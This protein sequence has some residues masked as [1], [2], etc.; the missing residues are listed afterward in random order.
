MSFNYPY[1]RHNPQDSWSIGS[2]EYGKSAAMGSPGSANSGTMMPEND[3]SPGFRNPWYSPSQLGQ[4]SLAGSMNNSPQHSPQL[5]LLQQKKQPFNNQLQT[6]YEN[7]D[8]QL[9]SQQPTIYPPSRADNPFNHYYTNQEVSLHHMPDRRMSAAVDGPLYNPYN[10]AMHLHSS[11][12]TNSQ[13][14]PPGSAQNALPF[15]SSMAYNSARRSS[16]AAGANSYQRTP[17]QSR[18]FSGVNVPP[19]APFIGVPPAGPPTK[20]T[21]RLTKIRSKN[22]LKPKIHHQ[23]KYRRRSINSMHISPV[24]ALSVYLTESYSMCQPQKFRYSKTSNPKRVLT[25]PSEPKFNNGYDNVDSDYILYVNDMLGVEEGRKYVVLDLLGSG[26]FGQ[27]VKC[28]NLANQSV[29]A[30]K[31][32]K[33]SAPFLNQSLSEV[34]LLE[35]LNQNSSSSNFIKLLDT[36]MHKEHLCLVFEI[37]ASN[38]YELIKQNQF[39]GLNMKLVKSFTRQLLEACAQLKNLQIIHCDIKPENILL[40]QPDKPDI[41]V[42]DFGSACFTR[43]TIYSYIQSR[44]YRSP[45]VIL[46]LPY[47]E[48]IDMW[49]LGCIVG[50]LFL[51]LPMFPGSSE[52]N[53]IWKIVDMLGNPPRHMI[54]VGRNAMN[55]FEKLP[56]PDANGKPKYKLKSHEDYLDFLRK[57]KGKDEA[58]KA[59]QPNK[60]YFSDRLLKDIILNYKMPSRKMTQTMVDR[61]MHDRH[62]LVDFLTKVLNF[63]PLE[64][65]TPQEALKHPFVSETSVASY[66]KVSSSEYSAAPTVV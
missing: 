43:Q 60:V 46:G 50:E 41:K 10:N 49:S 45:E 53:Q 58:T 3:Q 38:L 27:V 35:F 12:T 34:K 54:E 44:F 11:A 28:Q 52:Y 33:S 1:S 2:G 26:T 57:T 65:L 51:G 15:T 37:L 13:L 39:N 18:Y 21:P 22:D 61:E 64:R 19:S 63:N 31:V 29:V 66:P 17:L 32:I 4:Q 8:Q 25:K 5:S 6:T 24:N 23:P 47:T 59:E 7:A 20:T 16:V 42:I 40:C 48:S 36:F 56:S 9:S 55:Y 62:L 30:V 14:I